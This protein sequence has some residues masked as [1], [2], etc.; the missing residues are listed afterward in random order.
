MKSTQTNADT[1]VDQDTLPFLKGGG[2]MERRMRDHDWSASPLGSPE[3]WPLSLRSNVALMLNSRFGM[4]LAW[5]PELGFLYNDHYARIIADKHPAA[6]GRR[7]QDVWAEAWE[8]L[9]PL[10]DQAL[11]GDAVYFEDM[12]LV[13][14]RKGFDEETWWTFSYSPVRDD[15]GEIAGVF[16]ATHEAT[17]KVLGERRDAAIKARQ[18]QLFEQTP[19]FIVTMTGPEHRVN[20][21][22]D[23]H[24]A[25]FGSD[26]WVGKTIRD[27]FPSLADEGFFSILDAVYLR[28]ETFQASAAEVRYQRAPDLP[29]ETHYMTFVYAPVVEPTGPFR[30]CSAKGST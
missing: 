25:L 15:D 16:C 9:K 27:A 12:P 14:N 4:F 8:P 11:S 29:F 28:G 18:Q 13:M 21:V 5:G 7:F 23:A 19:S 2:E 20:F 22:N 26:D 17:Q 1:P 30:A 24:R 6:L 3:T 10:I